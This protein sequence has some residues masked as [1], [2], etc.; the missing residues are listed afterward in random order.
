MWKRLMVNP[1]MVGHG[2]SLAGSLFQVR[3]EEKVTTSSFPTNTEMISFS[4][5]PSLRAKPR[6]GDS[7]TAEADVLLAADD[8]KNIVCPGMLKEL[9]ADADFVDANQSA[10]RIT[11]RE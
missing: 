11:P 6:N 5:R 9:G 10:Y 8:V 4:P 7:F 1:H 3:K 2:P